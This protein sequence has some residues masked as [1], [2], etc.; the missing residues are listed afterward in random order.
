[1]NSALLIDAVVVLSPPPP[2]PAATITNA[3]AAPNE[4]SNLLL[5]I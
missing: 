4:T 5:D 2:H 3:T 1:M